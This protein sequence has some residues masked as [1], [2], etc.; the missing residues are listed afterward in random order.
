MDSGK[1][2]KEYA[3]SGKGTEGASS[4][5]EQ[6]RSLGSIFYKCDRPDLALDAFS[7]SYAM[8][9]DIRG[10]WGACL[11]AVFAGDPA[12]A[13]EWLGR[14]GDALR[15]RLAARPEEE[16]PEDMLFRDSGYC[17]LAF[18]FL[19]RMR[20]LDGYDD[21][22]VLP[23]E[24]EAAKEVCEGITDGLAACESDGDVFAACAASAAVRSG[25]AGVCFETLHLRGGRGTAA[26]GTVREII[27]S[28]G[29][30]EQLC[31]AATGMG[32]A[33]WVFSSFFSGC[34]LYLFDHLIKH[35]PSGGY[36]SAFSSMC[37]AMFIAGTV[38]TRKELGAGEWS[39]SSDPLVIS[40]AAEME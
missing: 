22:V 4:Y 24:T 10:A 36:A 28:G 8:D 23:C 35:A 15:Q 39:G 30:P 16:G 25:W 34:F 6:Y 1:P 14:T 2:E 18:S 9:G 27:S 20:L 13:E 3:G 29:D 5:P 32:D 19:V 12:G 26:A 7:G 33:A 17:S 38:L 37:R 40:R 31:T 21:I 11:S